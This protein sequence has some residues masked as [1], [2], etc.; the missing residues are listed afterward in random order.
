[1]NLA[2]TLTTVTN[3]AARVVTDHNRIV[4]LVM[5][6]LTAG[7]VFGLTQEQRDAE[8]GA[9]ESVIEGTDVHDAE[10]YL[11]ARYFDEEDQTSTEAVYIRSTDGTVL[12]KAG[13]L[14]ALDYQIAV[15]DS[16]SVTDALAGETPGDS[17]RNP[18][19]P[20]AVRL[21]DQP[22]PDLATQRRA[23]ADASPAAVDEAVQATLDEAESDQIRQFLPV[24]YEAGTSDA[25]G[26]RLLLTVTGEAAITDELSETATTV[27]ESAPVA[28]FTTA[29][30]NEEVSRQVL[31]E[32]AWLVV[33]MILLVLTVI[34]GFAYRDVTDVVVSFTGV[35]VTLLW[36]FGL[37]GWL[38]LLGQQTG[39]VV[40]VLAIAL[41]I[42]FSFHEFMRYRERRGTDDGIRDSLQRSTASVMIAF[43]LV[44]ATA[45]VGF[46][47]NL[48]NPVSLIRDLTVAF[49]LAVLSAFV[50]F[51]TLVPALKVSADGLWERFGFDRTAVALGKGSYLNRVLGGSVTVAQRASVVVIV[52]ALVVGAVGG[53]AFT[54]VDRQQFQDSDPL[55]D[56][57]WQSELPGPMAY[58]LHETEAAQQ[59]SFASDQFAAT[60][61]DPDSTFAFTQFLL[62]GDVATAETMQALATGKT[63]AAAADSDIV[64]NQGGGVGVRSPLTAMQ[65][66][67]ADNPDSAF[68][69]QFAAAAG[70]ETSEPETLRSLVPQQ[71]VP[72]TLDAFVEAAPERAAQVLEQTD[73][74]Y[75]SMRL[76]V[77]VQGGFGDDRAATMF[78]IEKQIDGATAASVTA[79]GS[80]TLNDAYITEIV[81]GIVTTMILALAG[82]FVVLA[83]VYRMAYNSATLGLVTALPI[84]LVLGLVFGGMVL[85][86]EPLTATTALIVSIAIG[87]GIDYN[88]HISD[89]FAT[90]LERGADVGTALREATTGTGGALL[91]SAVTSTGAF[92]LLIVAPLAAF[93]SIGVILGLTL[94]ASFLLSVFVLPSLLW[95]WA[96]FV[97]RWG[98]QELRRPATSSS[99]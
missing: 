8:G 58:E 79:V 51:T 13:L 30:L 5:L 81:D 91:G 86:G 82:V 11:D 78:E 35:I 85:L 14:A 92:A 65:E 9:S 41:S 37:M 59:L 56:P 19:V 54:E 67:A 52:L 88:I 32:L 73:D 72:A 24:D 31:P 62:R 26:M 64:L 12:N 55:S 61:D 60:G 25:A 7:V 99:D 77:P 16:E 44:T 70:T 21:A 40:P 53:V 17:I 74:G 22:D 98:E 93:Q 90:E 38:G 43:V 27:D 29:G 76:L 68:A 23:V 36:T 28:V 18:A 49:I 89:R 10:T 96:R 48:M 94:A 87:L 50:I 75:A 80:G 3:G 97:R 83:A 4:L 42:D 69:E 46:L 95:Q 34:L 66:V 47:P 20:V 45:V 84:A 15:S 71:N 57:G 2:D 63:A 1:M 6:V 33:P 39:L